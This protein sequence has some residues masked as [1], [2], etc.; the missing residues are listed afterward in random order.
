[1]AANNRLSENNPDSSDLASIRVIR[2]YS[3]SIISDRLK[4]VRL[5]DN[6]G[7]LFAEEPI[8]S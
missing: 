4:L 1:M 5:S 2:N 6:I 7:T 3:I 8:E